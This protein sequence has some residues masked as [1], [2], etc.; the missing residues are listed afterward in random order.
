VRGIVYFSQVF[1]S[2]LQDAQNGLALAALKAI[3]QGEFSPLTIVV[4]C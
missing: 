4:N 3:A 2:T 1:S